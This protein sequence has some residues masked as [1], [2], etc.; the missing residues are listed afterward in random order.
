MILLPLPLFFHVIFCSKALKLPSPL[1]NLKFFPKE[2]VKLPPPP[3]PGW[4]MR[5]F[6]HPW[7]KYFITTT[8]KLAENILFP[9]PFHLLNIISSYLG[10][11]RPPWRRNRELYT[12][13]IVL[14]QCC[15]SGEQKI[16]RRFFT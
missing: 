15:G 7:F 5:N 3:G 6:I 13:Y 12:L 8:E 16:E 10:L 1:H 4:G 14:T 2:F 11:L 9:L